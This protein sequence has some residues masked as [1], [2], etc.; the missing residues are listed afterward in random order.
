MFILISSAVMNE[1]IKFIVDEENLINSKDY[2][3]NSILAAAATFM[4]R[5]LSA[6]IVTLF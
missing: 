5:Y 6:T 3:E 2:G 4:R 1:I